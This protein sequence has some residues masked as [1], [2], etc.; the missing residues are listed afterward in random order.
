VDIRLEDKVALVTGASSGLGREI[1]IE[2]ARSGAH[3]GLTYQT[4]ESGAKD[5]GAAV[6]RAGRRSLLHQADLSSAGEVARLFER[7]G[8]HFGRLDILVNN[9]GSM[10]ERCPIAEMSDELFDRVF[11]VNMRS[12]FLCCRAAVPLLEKQPG[13]SI[14]NI[15]SVAAK[16]GGGPG[17][18]AYA[19]AKGAVSTFTLGLSRELAARRIRVNAV[20]PGVI[21]T[22][23]HERFTTA[24]QL[25]ALR[26]Q[27][28]LGRLGEAHEIAGAVLF[29]ASDY[30]SYVTGEIIAVN[31]GMA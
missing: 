20:A 3:V 14:V 18:V 13:S 27:I 15:S 25:E 23:F 11:A 1:A 26:R 24:E 8:S 31:G 21:L 10:I 28:P 7:I 29:L 16:T 2:L 12:V 22:P 19:A 5:T 17:A 6:E 9:A 4:N 30:A